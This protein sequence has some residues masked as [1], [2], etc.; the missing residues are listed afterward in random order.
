MK[1]VRIYNNNII[2]AKDGDKEVILTGN[3]IGF[4]KKANDFV[5]EKKIDKKYTFEDKQRTQINQLLN[6][7]PVLYFQIAE[8][9]ASKATKELNITLSNQIL[10]SLTDHL[11]Y[12]VERK[13]RN[14]QMPNLMLTEIRTLYKDE[15]KLGLWSL[16]LIEANTKI[17]LGE[18]EA[19]YIAMH[20]V[21]ANM[22]TTTGNA[23]KIL[24]FIKDIQTIIENTFHLSFDENELD[25]S[26]LLT[27]LK[28]LAQH[29][30]QNTKKEPIDLDQLYTLL[31]G[32][33]AL[34]ERCIENIYEIVKMNYK[35]ELTQDEKVYLMIHIN[36][37]IN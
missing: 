37:I 19:S 15:F 4:Q 7:T 31:V 34:M 25:Y 16:K 17:E 35:Y 12:A 1:I 22:G 6:R 26:R 30:F 29:I 32:N 10:I 11:W 23:T 5:D 9:I 8:A 36:K 28:F 18:H 20:I 27:H 13:K 14:M 2:A 3:G 33:H 21:N 24:R